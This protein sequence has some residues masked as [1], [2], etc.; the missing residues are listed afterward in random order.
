MGCGFGIEDRED[1]EQES[2]WVGIRVGMW[3]V[4]L[5]I[6]MVGRP[7]LVIFAHRRTRGRDLRGRGMLG[8][9]CRRLVRDVCGREMGDMVADVGGELIGLVDAWYAISVSR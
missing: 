7:C 8:S 9:R 2:P 3:D 4:F 6:P 5:G 1:D